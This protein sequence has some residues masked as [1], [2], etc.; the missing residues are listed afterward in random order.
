MQTPNP[1]IPDVINLLELGTQLSAVSAQPIVMF[2]VRL[3]TRFFSQDDGS[4]ELRVRVY[5]DKVHID[6]HEPELT[7]DE[8]TWGHHFWNQTWKAG[9]NKELTI[10][11]WQQL[12][13]RFD[14]PRAAWIARALKPLNSSEPLV[15]PTIVKKGESW[16]RAPLARAL[17]SYWIAL[18][19]KNGNLIV[20]VKGALIPDILHAGPDPK[21]NSVN[22]T[23]SA[24]QLVI[25]DKMNW[26]VDFDEAEKVGMGIRTKLT[27]QDALAGLDF[28]FVFGLKDTEEG[29]EFTT[30]LAELLNAH[31]YTD[32]LSFITQGTPT[33]NTV[34][35]KSGFSSSDQR[36]EIS[37]AAEWDTPIFQSGDGSNADVAATAFGKPIMES[38]FAFLPNATPKEQLDAQQ[39]NTAL[40]EATWGYFLLQLLDIGDT[41]SNKI[42]LEDI[43]WARNH[44]IE[45]VRAS[46]PLPAIRI[47]K[48]PYGILPVTSIDAWRPT[49]G[50]DTQFTRDSI[51]REYLI[52]LRDIWRRSYSNIPRLGRTED[53]PD[54]FAN[55][56]GIDKDLV[57]VLSMDG[58]SSNYSVR[59]F[60][61]RHYLENLWVFLTADYYSDVFGV[62]EETVP[63]EPNLPEGGSLED[64]R[65]YRIK[66]NAWLAAVAAHEQKLA[67]YDTKSADTPAW[68]SVQ[69]QRTAALLQTLG[70]TWKPRLARGVYT[71]YS[72]NLSSL[73]VQT[74]HDQYLSP[75]YIQALLAAQDLDTIRFQNFQPPLTPNSEPPR[76][77]LYLLLRHSMLLE[78]AAAAFELLEKPIQVDQIDRNEPELIDVS[79]GIETDTIWRRLK[80]IIAVEDVE[81]RTSQIE[82]DK[83]LFDSSSSGESNTQ[84]DPELKQLNEFRSGLE[85][86]KSL[87]VAK[88]E[89]LMA[90]TLDLCSH[91]LDA[92]ITSFATKRLAE[93]RKAHPVGSLLGGYG[94]VMNLKPDMNK[95][96][97]QP[98]PAEQ[99]PIYQSVNNPGFTHT[100][101]LTQATT[102]ALLRSG[103]LNHA[104][105]GAPDDLLAIDLSSERV[106]LASW[107]LDGVRQ[108]QPLG[109]LLGYR[110]ERALQEKGA[111][112][113]IARFRELT[114]LIARKLEQGGQAIT[115]PVEDIAANNVVDGLELLKRFQ[116]GMSTSLWNEYS[117][118]FGPQVGNQ[119][120]VLPPADDTNPDFKNI[121]DS[122][123]IL[124]NAVDAVSDALTA[125]NAYQIVRGN[126]LRAGATVESISGGEAALPELEVIRTPRT[127]IALTHR[128]V[129]LFKGT[130]T[131]PSDW[132][133]QYDPKS[134]FR[135][136][137]EP[138]LNNWAGKILGHPFR[139][140]CLIERLDPSTGAVIETK[141]M[142]LNQLGLSP[143]DFVYA[144]EGGQG[145]RLS[146]IE[147]RILFTIKRD[148]NGFP[149]DAKLRISH[150]RSR[151]WKSDE[152]SFGDF[153]E[154]LR[155]VRKLFAGI[156]AIDAQD[157]NLPE[158]NVEA[159]VDLVELKKR[160]D[161]A[162]NELRKI[163]IEVQL[164]L[165]DPSLI[166]S[167]IIVTLIMRSL[168]FGVLDGVLL[169]VAGYSTADTQTLLI[170]ADTILK[171][172][173]RRIE[174]LS[175]LA[176]NF[177]TSTAAPEAKR[178]YATARLQI[179]FGKSFGVLPRFKAANA[180]ELGKALGDSTQI[181]DNDPLASIT[182]FQRAV[183]VRDGVSRLN[184]AINYSEILFNREA[185][186][187]SIAQ[188]P[189]RSEDRWV[190]LPL[191]NEKSLTGGKLSLVVQSTVPI[192][193]NLQLAGVL[194]DEWVE[195]VPNA[196]ETTGIAFQYD[197]PNYV[198]PQSILIA[199]PP[200]LDKPWTVHSLQQVILETLDL[201][202]IRAVDPDSLG[203]VGHYLPAMYFAYNN[204]GDTVSTDFATIR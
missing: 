56:K 24:D 105:A 49:S 47:G 190:G 64:I 82:I 17:P 129:T 180:V 25:D 177:N 78:Y 8:I 89:Q 62:L 156:R 43:A 4:Q 133:G 192:D 162:E 41:S 2:P 29:Y 178:D 5:P 50:Q 30:Q 85:H 169:P 186:K 119:T 138:Y 144:G 108:G 67:I 170:Q 72:A 151:E 136:N 69:E 114:P 198:P 10:T 100:P 86:L 18:G 106:R 155:T 153:T 74:G 166:H 32:G 27:E 81:G 132:V 124:E 188:L 176:S 179:I 34:D 167:E 148:P 197:Q 111:A 152:S 128:V 160:A 36:H 63:E 159:G 140:R 185:L 194:I 202:R 95:S 183:R 107:L 90:G 35:A 168:S 165:L 163:L 171:Q 22:S 191:K 37:Y 120:V 59:N 80:S 161:D 19:Y 42:G 53:R 174:Q 75:N 118:P 52:R 51:L 39:M 14:P 44:F 31:H 58:L 38:V 134:A 3:E 54:D 173:N 113:F 73:L 135:A 11:A 57:E 33:N 1:D 96:E 21:A 23:E 184:D 109:A 16:T 40:W 94:W 87:D 26:L 164:Q 71:S 116:K 172:F 48:Q 175:E 13:D 20:N 181:Q 141:M 193:P 99:G 199:V 9:S 66:H 123:A 145:G 92:W 112:E 157:L 83:Y 7:D 76:S 93:I 68:W 131:I 117:I 121:R 45:F 28:L 6:T 15:F 187:L 104:V 196:T 77:L 84:N 115:V 91:R 79:F 122:I 150:D 127:G 65:I 142:R 158:Q 110:F 61:G 97:I 130:P 101:S 154:L 195:V 126:P 102:V 189:Y 55:E 204:A 146:E 137:A 143:L 46:G 182:W 98:P 60:M 70:I 125:E 200:E 203:E 88:L 139:L 147:Q 149:E 12:A 103:H 201:A